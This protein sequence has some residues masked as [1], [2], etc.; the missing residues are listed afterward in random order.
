MESPEPLEQ[1]QYRLG[2]LGCQAQRGR[3]QLLTCLQHQHVGALFVHVGVGQVSSAILQRIDHV[4]GEILADRDRAQVGG[5]LLG[6]S[7]DSFITGGYNCSC[8]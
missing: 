4:G 6:F 1:S 8:W 5:Q 3:T 7:S 2:G